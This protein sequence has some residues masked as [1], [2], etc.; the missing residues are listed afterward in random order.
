MTD[1]IL[2]DAKEGAALLGISL[3]SF[4]DL[5]KTAGFPAARSLGPRSQRWLR[6]ELEQY[7][8]ALPT[9]RRDEPPQLAAAR[10]AKATGR[11]VLPVPFGG[12]V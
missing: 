2:V 4:R 3:R 12:H 7:A 1:R 9:V 11:A 5:M 10:A 8:V 6:A